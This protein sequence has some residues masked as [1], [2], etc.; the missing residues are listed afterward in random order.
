WGG[1]KQRRPAPHA[2]N[3]LATAGPAR[4]CP[5]GISERR[6]GG[7]WRPRLCTQRPSRRRR[8]FLQCGSAKWSGQST[9][10]LVALRQIL[11]GLGAQVKKATRS[12][13]ESA[14][15]SASSWFTG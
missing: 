14:S 15:N 10:G 13:C 6:S 9:T 1:S 5:V 8:A 3:E 7:A 2:E 4:H 11:G 12:A